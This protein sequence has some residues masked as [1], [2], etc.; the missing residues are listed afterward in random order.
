MAD[1]RRWM[2]L[3][4]AMSLAPCAGV[5][6]A[7]PAPSVASLRAEIADL[8]VARDY[9]PMKTSF[10]LGLERHSKRPLRY[11]VGERVTLLE[12]RGCGS[13][14]HIWETN[15]SP[16][17]IFLL[18][19]YID[20][21]TEPSIRCTLPELIAAA[22]R[23]DQPFVK[24]TGGLIANNSHNL[25]LPV[26]F[27]KSMRIDLIPTQGYGLIFLQLDYRIED[28]S[29]K[30]AR[31]VQT[32][33][34]E[35][36]AL[37]Y[38]N[39]PGG[40]SDEDPVVGATLRQHTF[41][42]TGDGRFTVRGPGII[43]KLALNARRPGAR[44]RLRFDGEATAAVDV[45][46]AD[47]FGPFRGVAFNNNRCY[48]PMPFQDSAEIEIAGASE[49][50]EW[51]LD[52]DIEPVS[53]FADDWRY[54]HARSYATA[55]ATGYMPHH[56]TYT[57]GRGHW[58]GMSLY[59][60]GHDHGGGDIAVVDGN[61]DSPAFLHGING[62][63]Y[64]SFA[65]FGRGENFPYSEAFHNDI[66]R[67]R[68]HVE[69]PYPFRDSLYVGWYV[70]RNAHPRSVSLWYQ[71]SPADRTIDPGQLPG[72]TWSVFGQVYVP[73]RDDGNTPNT[74]D[75]DALFAELPDPERLDA[76]ET[77]EVSRRFAHDPEGQ[78]GTYEGWARQPAIGRFLDLMYV[79]R[80]AIDV[81]PASHM[82]YEARAMM[83]QT[84]LA[85]PRPMDV[86]IQL[87][88]D[89]PMAVSLNGNDVYEDMA[90]HSGFVTRTF[91]AKLSKGEN[92]LLIRMA[93]TP[94]MNTCWAATNLRILGR[95]G[96][97]ITLDLQP[98]QG[99]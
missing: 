94:N 15:A 10:I 62:E 28:E 32:G 24:N 19:F 61:T 6:T 57:R 73:L 92:T 46:I 87:S 4:I 99:D 96:K 18:E 53:A 79:Y 58:V 98:P 81:G 56:V 48:L 5:A 37:H 60:T 80:H 17:G 34:G 66:G 22:G 76:G 70:L 9:V 38:E 25:Y 40:G 41:R 21:E 95:D 43:R 23:C 74:S 42:F 91:P 89:D 59:N 86:T 93:D 16:E 47:F 14:R 72:L 29:L 33:T 97:D 82:G 1:P 20:G 2:S 36:M 31:L 30:G 67:T 90:I 75:A 78:H 35:E 8:H 68:L 12:A 13:L 45:D 88:Y 50:E 65:Y 64:F 54:F 71:D 11:E 69:N 39:L 27:S 83:A 84:K 63:D 77:I 26:P 3:L 52:V 51:Q 44:L 7:D 49:D 55:S 85:A